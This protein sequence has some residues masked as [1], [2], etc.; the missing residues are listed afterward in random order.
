MRQEGDAVV[1]RQIPPGVV[2]LVEGIE[3]AFGSEPLEDS[4]GMTSTA[5][6]A[7]DVM[8]LGANIQSVKRFL[9]Q[10]RQVIGVLAAV[11]RLDH[12]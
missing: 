6:G 2:V 3:A 7:V 4:P 10:D 11:K 1:R 8:A 9:Q 12:D 5:E